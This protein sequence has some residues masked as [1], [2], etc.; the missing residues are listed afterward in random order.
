MTAIVA[1]PEQTDDEH[2]KTEAV[3]YNFFHWSITAD[4][5]VNRFASASLRKDTFPD[6]FYSY[7]HWNGKQLNTQ[8]VGFRL[9]WD[10]QIQLHK[11]TRTGKHLWCFTGRAVIQSQRAGDYDL[12]LIPG[13]AYGFRSYRYLNAAQ[14]K[15]QRIRIKPE[16]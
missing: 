3:W 8:L 16:H 9:A 2:L 13:I 12:F 6:E 5:I 14:R 15:D 4:V 10:M 7:E 11:K 1:T